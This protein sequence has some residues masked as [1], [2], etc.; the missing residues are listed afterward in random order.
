M[1]AALG[2]AKDPI[3][4]RNLTDALKKA[5]EELGNLKFGPV[6]ERMR[7]EMTQ[8]SAT[9]DGTQSGLF[10]KQKEIAAKSLAEVQRGSKEYLQIQQETA[11]LDVQIRQ[12]SGQEVIASVRARIAEINGETQIGIIQRLESERDVWS[13][14]LSG[15][16]LTAA[17]RVEVERELNT[18]IAGLNKQRANQA[19]EIARLD[20]ASE[21]AISRMN[22]EAK[23]ASLAADLSDDKVTAQQKYGILKGL[24]DQEYQLNVK[25]LQDQLVSLKSQPVEYERVYDQIKELTARHNLDMAALKKQE[26]KENNKEA[27]G[28][29]AFADSMFHEVE[30]AQSAMIGNL[31][32]GRRS[33][34]QASLSLLQNL[35]T[36]EIEKDAE[37]VTARLV[38]SESS[39][40][41][42]TAIKQSGVLYHYLFEA[43]KTAVTV[44]GEGAR[45][46]ATVGGEA[47]RLGVQKT[48]ASAS[49]ATDAAI[50]IAKI[51][52][53]AAQT[54]AAITAFLAP[55]L[56]PYA[57]IGAAVI[58][59]IVLA[60]AGHVIS[61]A[62]GGYDVP[63][64]V[65]PMTQLH[66]REMVLPAPLADRVRDM[67]DSGGAVNFHVYA[68]DTQ[69][70][71][72]FFKN[73]GHH[74]VKS[75][76][77]QHRGFS[78]P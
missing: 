7:T 6:M 25:S 15:E 31:L 10:A 61:S 69:S 34:S 44:A 40:A 20:N 24:A 22:I 36:R 78:T 49:M 72:Q 63:A 32:S 60:E 9:W 39:E 51:G 43:Q 37:A 52:N 8:L 57:P 38:L 68:N 67:S 54:F 16:R 65:N 30:N 41:R 59:A 27:K 74:I 4:I 58:S 26:V 18:T 77:Q 66:Q 47:A 73:N 11:R 29:S 42:K 23:K 48:S 5:N 53:Y 50:T 14:T 45:T 46:S 2:V 33:F 75:L 64:G 1:N 70:V 19:R 17:Q 21:I 35:L 56:G 12:S 28:E 13:Q 71:A 3:E 62:E 55:V 76:R